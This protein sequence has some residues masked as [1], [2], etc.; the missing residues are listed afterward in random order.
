M[1]RMNDGEAANIKPRRVRL[2]TVRSGDSAQSI[3]S[4]MAYSDYQLDRFLVLNGLQANTALKAG[5][6]VKIVTY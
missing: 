6:R 2:V 3:A 4:R 5:S 1:A